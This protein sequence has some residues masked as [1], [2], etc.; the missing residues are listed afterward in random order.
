MEESLGIEGA[1]MLAGH[2]MGGQIA[3]LALAV[4]PR[5]THAVIS[6][7]SPLTRRAPSPGCVTTRAGTCPGSPRP[8]RSRRSRRD[9]RGNGPSSWPPPTTRT[10]PRT[11]P[12]PSW[13]RFRPGLRT[14]RG[15]RARTSSPRRLATRWWSG[16]R[17]RRRS[18][19][20]WRRSRLEPVQCR[21]AVDGGTPA[22]RG[23]RHT[24]DEDASPSVCRKYLATQ[25]TVI[26]REPDHTVDGGFAET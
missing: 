5:I 22:E 21:H 9:W 17:G 26:L 20:R 19:P 10:S 13:T 7:E 23:L 1:P 24:V 11:G 15:G 12:S 18:S 16:S 4:S 6:S 3:F 2:S 14:S 8:A 25:S